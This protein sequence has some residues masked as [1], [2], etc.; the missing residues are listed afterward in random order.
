MRR[1]ISLGGTTKVIEVWTYGD[2]RD[3]NQEPKSRPLAASVAGIK[4]SG[5]P[6]LLH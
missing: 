6:W 2:G 3:T 5:Y 1:T 4:G